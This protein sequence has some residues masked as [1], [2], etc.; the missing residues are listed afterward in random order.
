MLEAI[1]VTE[2]LHWAEKDMAKKCVLRVME[3]PVSQVYVDRRSSSVLKSS[4]VFLQKEEE[5]EGKML[6][7]SPYRQFKRAQHI[8][9]TSTHRDM[10][11]LVL[12]RSGNQSYGEISQSQL[13]RCSWPGNNISILGS[14]V[15]LSPRPGSQIS[16]AYLPRVRLPQLAK[17]SR[18]GENS[19][20][21]PCILTAIKP[22]N[23]ESEKAKFF[24]SDFRYNPQF[25]YSN[26]ASPQVLEKHSKASDRF[27]TQ[28]VRIMELALHKYGNYEKFEQATGGS[29]LTKSRIWAHVKKYMEKEGCVGEIVVHL[30]DDL[31]SRA[32]MTV[33]NGRPTLTINISAAREQWLEGMLRHEIGTHYFR[34]IN[35]SQQP[36]SSGAG[37]KKLGLKPVNPTEEGLA[38]IHSVLFRRDPRLWRAALLYYTVHQAAHMSFTQLFQ[39]LA[40]FVHDP[41]TRWDYCVRAK[42]GQTD[43]SQPGCFNKD[44]VYLD[45]ILKI[46]RHREKIDFQLLT[47]LGKVSYEDVERLKSL[48]VMENVR[49]P[50]F[51]QDQARYAEQLQKIMAVNQ[52]TDEELQT[53]I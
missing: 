23:V 2:H 8:V 3:K 52:L 15:S 34:S 32:S 27:L 43:T 36:W 20:K 19:T 46:L 16:R 25:E 26:P 29:L 9:S 47:A 49:I 22:S 51:L 24:K 21:K 10:R 53:L 30:T 17:G 44:Q 7:H 13:F 38:S 12:I 28:A 5:T 18:D 31:L 6:K 4:S 45:G 35:N 48:A 50:H 37:R 42:R 1:Q 40:R 11:P 39:E 14:P 41:G 33:V